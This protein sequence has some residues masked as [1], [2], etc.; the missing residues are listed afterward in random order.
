VPIVTRNAAKPQQLL[1]RSPQGL[2]GIGPARAQAYAA[3]GLYN[4]RDLLYHLPNRYRMRPEPGPVAALV[5]GERGA[6]VGQVLRSSLRRRG[7]RSTVSLRVRDDSGDE[8]LVLLF[9]RAYL[10]KSL[11]KQRVWVAGKVER[12]AA[13][14][15]LPRL[16]AADY[17][18]LPE[19]A[20][21]PASSCL[22][23][24]RLPVGI[25]PRVHRKLLATILEADPP[26][27][28]RDLEPGE[29]TLAEALTAIHLADDLESARRARQRLAYDEAWALSLEVGARRAALASHGAPPVKVSETLHR[30]LLAKLPHTP[31]AAQARVFQELRADLAEKRRPMGRLLQGDVG[32]GKTLVAFYAL[33]A[34]VGC[35]RQGA[36]MAPTEVLAMQHATALEEL[37]ASGWPEG[38]GPRVALITGRGAAAEKR[39]ARAAAADGSAKLIVGTHSLQGKRMEFADLAVTVVDEQHRFGV[40]QRMRFRGKGEETHLLVMTATPIPRTLSLTAYGELDVSLLDELPPGRSPRVTRYVTSGKQPAMWRSLAKEISAGGQ[41]YVVCPSISSQEE[42]NHSVES[43]LELVRNRLGPDV[44]VGSVHG[45]MPAEERDRVLDAFRAGELSVLVATVIVEVGLDVAAATFVVIPD[46]ARFGLATLHQIRGRVGRGE[47]PGRCLLLGPLSSAGPSRERVDALCSTDDGFVLAEEDLR[48][49]GP[50]EMLG[51]RQSGM[52]GFLVLDPVSDVEL[53]AVARPRAIKAG[54]GLSSEKLAKLRERAFPS[55]KLV[56]E[57]LLAGG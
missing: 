23:I 41:G 27:E 25:A 44:S 22:P 16:L 15:A 56:V 39:A 7:R 3:A 46:P 20:M 55:T 31:T 26:S 9:N 30:K 11:A 29:P 32:S 54:R 43:T 17:E 38:N 42:E 28:W 18:R 57:N 1:D 5:D 34:A 47:R 53:L 40:R 36:I 24:Y 50:G 37:V 21:G 12:P 2:P 49:R 52:P 10:A 14:G 51:T 45:R 35:G 48:L 4:C 8:A 13:D 33:L 19:E 6:L